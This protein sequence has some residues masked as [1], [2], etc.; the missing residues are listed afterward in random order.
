MPEKSTLTK[1]RIREAA[2][3]YPRAV[4]EFFRNDGLDTAGALTFFM[5]LAFFPGLLA[6]ISILTFVGASESGT[7]WILEILQIALAPNG[8]QLSGD[9][10]QLLEISEHFLDTLAANASGTTLAIFLGSLGALWST[11]AYVVA[12]G[13]AL[14]RLFGV[15]E[16]RPQWKRRPQMY[17]ITVIIM[18]LAIV[19]MVLLIATGTIAQGLSN[20][21]GLGDGFVTLLNW[22]KPP[23]LLVVFLLVIA[24]L[25]YY[26]PNVKRPKFQWFSPGTLTAISALGLSSLGFTFYLG[27]FAKYSATY[28]T[29]GALIILVL[30][31][32]I[33]NIALI[34]GALVDIEFIRLRQLRTG[35]PSAEEVQ[36]PLRDSTLIAKKNLTNYKDLVHAQEIRLRHGGDPLQD[37][38]V[39]PELKAKRQTRILPIAVTGLAVW[40]ATRWLSRRTSDQRTD[41]S[42]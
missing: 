2:S 39:D 30:A 42:R 26:T 31:G 6:L 37:M 38:A 18:I 16:G 9:A 41:K 10:K 32:W 28:G 27:H 1:Q 24:L 34:L 3:C 4:R 14:N 29:I 12:F 22:G 23:A 35:M 17:L 20:V 33:G 25:Y 19:S 5:L 36:L 7:Q 8:E 13:R 40:A 21:F 11:S 15:V